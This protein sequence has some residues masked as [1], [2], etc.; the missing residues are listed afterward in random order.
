MP[1]DANLIVETGGMAGSDM[2]ALDALRV[3]ERLLDGVLDMLASLSLG[4][5]F[6]QVMLVRNNITS[7]IQ[8]ELQAQSD[9]LNTQTET[10][11]ALTEG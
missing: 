1:N 11:P 10:E 8:E 7:Y 5:D 4:L 6:T 2:S 9:E 3:T